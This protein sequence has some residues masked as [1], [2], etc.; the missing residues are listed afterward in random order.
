VKLDTQVKTYKDVSS[1]VAILFMLVIV[2][3]LDHE[4]AINHRVAECVSQQLSL[5]QY[6][7]MYV[8]VNVCL[9]IYVNIL[10]FL[11]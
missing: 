3:I 5:P 1:F 10:D 7:C 9:S 2:F 6:S 11:G 8:F 4:Q